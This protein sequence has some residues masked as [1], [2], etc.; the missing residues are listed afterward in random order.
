MPQPITGFTKPE[1]VAI[2]RYLSSRVVPLTYEGEGQAAVR[3][4]GTFFRYRSKV[5]LVTA[6]HVVDGIDAAL[7]GVPDRPNGNVA[8]WNLN[9]VTVYH[10][11][12]TD[13]F[14]VAVIELLNPN[15][16]ARVASSWHVLDE[17]EVVEPTEDDENFVLAGY[18]AEAVE[19]RGG[20]LVP[21]PMLQLFTKRYDGETDEP[22][23][24]YDLLLRFPRSAK[25][26]YG[27]ER[28]TPHLGG[29]SG[30]VVYARREP[31][32][33]LW[34]PDQVLRPVGIQVSMK[35]GEYIRVKRWM[36]L[37]QL[38]ELIPSSSS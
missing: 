35:R 23:P 8:I 38:L 7:L 26:I 37:W 24:D 22:V 12:D 29:V 4:T 1:H 28:S 19:F 6:A 14:D 30:T 3:G 20:G 11:R 32:P 13:R 5:Y 31:P 16:H 36:L 10:P 18:P 27:D 17:T 9:D 15:F 21:K 25:A 33:G 2:G 34:S